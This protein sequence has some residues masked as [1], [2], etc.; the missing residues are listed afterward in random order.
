MKENYKNIGNINLD[1]CDEAVSCAGTPDTR[2]KL[3]RTDFNVVRVSCNELDGINGQWGTGI[4]I[5]PNKVLTA[6]HVAEIERHCFG[7]PLIVYTGEN[8][9]GSVPK[10]YTVASVKI[11]PSYNRNAA[12][13]YKHDLAVLTTIESFTQ[14]KSFSRAP[15][16]LD[17]T[18]LIW[19]GYPSD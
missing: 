9:A 4:V 12:D 13:R 10:K 6:A 2:H 17:F 16:P 15:D 8:G 1:V 18:G 11:H 19:T 7:E 14:Y 3:E 5:G